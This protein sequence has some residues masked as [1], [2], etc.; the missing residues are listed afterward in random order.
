MDEDKVILFQQA[1]DGSEVVYEEVVAQAAPTPAPRSFKKKRTLR[2]KDHPTLFEL[3]V[4]KAT[5][6]G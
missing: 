5:D 6:P 4:A 3:G 1:F 2:P